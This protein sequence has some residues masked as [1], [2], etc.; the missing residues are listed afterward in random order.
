MSECMD[1]AV[2]TAR[3]KQA[4]ARVSAEVDYL[5]KLDSALGDGDH[6]TAMARVCETITQTIDGAATEDLKSLLFDLGWG[7]MSAAGGSSSTLYG[8]L[9]MGMSEGVPDGGVLD[10]AAVAAVLESAQ[11]EL[12]KNTKA[13]PGGKT[14]MDAFVPA[15]QAARSAAD[16]GADAGAVLAA[17]AAAAAEGAESTREMKATFGRARNLGDRT[18]GHLDPGATSMAM[19]FEGLATE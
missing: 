1:Y 5:S 3:L 15:V 13:Q 17:S 16:S 14:L 8:S 4:A 6:G 2:F 7:I 10:G 11:T 18:I 19:F 9:F 12:Q